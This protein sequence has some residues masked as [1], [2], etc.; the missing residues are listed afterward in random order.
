MSY[1]AEGEGT[2]SGQR[3]DPDSRATCATATPRPLMRFVEIRNPSNGRTVRAFL[4]DTGA[5]GSMVPPR[6]YDCV[7]FVWRAIGEDMSRGVV[8]VEARLA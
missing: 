5:F 3:L 6:K 1:Y 8:D 2:A 7:P 4:N